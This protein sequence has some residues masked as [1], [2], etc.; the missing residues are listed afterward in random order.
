M[1]ERGAGLQRLRSVIV[2]SEVTAI[3]LKPPLPHQNRT[4]ALDNLL[5]IPIP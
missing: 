3:S 1:I 4:Q 5:R 2:L